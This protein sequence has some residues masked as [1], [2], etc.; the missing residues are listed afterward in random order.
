M[1]RKIVSRIATEVTGDCL[2][3]FRS[4]NDA[5]SQNE[6]GLSNFTNFAPIA[7]HLG[8]SF[9]GKPL[10]PEA[11]ALWMAAF[12]VERWATKHRAGKDAVDSRR[13]M[14]NY[15][16]L[17]EACHRIPEYDMDEIPD[18]L[19]EKI[20]NMDATTVSK[21]IVVELAYNL[22]FYAVSEIYDIRKHSIEMSIWANLGIPLMN[23][24]RHELSAIVW[25][26]M[27]QCIHEYEKLFDERVHKGIP[28]HNLGICMLHRGDVERAKKF[29]VRAYK[30]DL[31]TKGKIRAN[32]GLAMKA[33]RHLGV[34]YFGR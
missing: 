6:N 34:E 30:E 14:I 7:S 9:N 32:G 2:S 5:Y 28:L 1:K 33:M 23:A 16:I 11:V 22:A 20:A 29:F 10:T 17:G 27:L 12:K 31:I 4:R 25:G 15:G 26:K 13:D 19:A 8:F 21:R 3:I 18:W 24:G